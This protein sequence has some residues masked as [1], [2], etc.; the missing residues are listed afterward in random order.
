MS[1]LLQAPRQQLQLRALPLQ[2]L[3]SQTTQQQPHPPLVPMALPLHPQ[4][5][6]VLQPRLQQLPARFVTD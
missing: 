3:P 6:L 2:L 4:L 1:I 5:P